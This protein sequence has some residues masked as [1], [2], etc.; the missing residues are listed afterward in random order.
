MYVVLT[1]NKI[2]LKEINHFTYTNLNSQK[3]VFSF[4][5]NNFDKNKDKILNFTYLIVHRCVTVFL[6][7]P[8]I[9]LLE[10][11]DDVDKHRKFLQV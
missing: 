7:V 6:C 4:E 2:G 3:M 9:T 5:I 11:W 1:I 10:V 8:L